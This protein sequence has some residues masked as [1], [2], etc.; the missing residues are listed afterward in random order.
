M[1]AN[2]TLYLAILFAAVFGLSMLLMRN[3]MPD[4]GRR[5]M[6]LTPAS[7]APVSGTAGDWS[8]RIEKISGP[9]ARLAI[10]DQGWEKS[11]LRIRFMHAGYRGGKAATI[12]F[13]AKTALA[14]A[15]PALLLPAVTVSGAKLP[16]AMLMFALLTAAAIGF[17][18]PNAVLAAIIRRRQRDIFENFPDVLDLMTVCIEAG[19]SVDAAINRVAQE[20][21]AT[22]PAISGELHMVTLELG[23]GGGKEKALRN[24]ATRTG[25]GDIDTLVTMLIQ[26]EQ[27]GTSIGD[28]LRVHAEHLRIKRRRIA[29]EA[30]A[31]VS[32]KLLMP[33]IFCIFPALMLIML[34][35]AILQIYRVLLP[36]LG[37]Q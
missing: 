2:A 22:S 29:E 9:L 11:S 36:S 4:A 18:L 31:K 15:L 17:Y 1:I 13:A 20:A 19:L 30:A 10:P 34:G 25:V 3:L 16:A 21:A 33:L 5:R 32:L 28:S 26:A 12:Y 27:F 35:P 6:K 7:P 24:L 37:G 23:A 8:A 14:V